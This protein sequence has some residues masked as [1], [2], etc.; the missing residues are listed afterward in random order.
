MNKP[1]AGFYSCE[2]TARVQTYTPL[3]YFSDV[4]KWVY[5]M[6]Y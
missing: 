3:L 5:E 6:K 1:T 2:Y 4:A